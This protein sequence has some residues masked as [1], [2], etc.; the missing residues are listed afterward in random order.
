M[1]P[2]ENA[3]VAVV[4][5]AGSG[6]GRAVAVRLLNDDWHVALVGRRVDA[7]NETV[8]LAR[9][10]GDRALVAACDVGRSDDV[11][12]MAGQVA[13]RFADGPHVLVNAAGINVPQRALAVL[14]LDDFRQMID[15]NLT[16]SFLCA[17]AFLPG[18]RRRGAGTVV[19]VVSDAGISASP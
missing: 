18:M 4:T 10:A 19:N 17:R 7:L 16:G 12:A 5:G 1:N 6:V 8:T 9:D 2:G 14:S 3:K 15:V 13:A 11:D